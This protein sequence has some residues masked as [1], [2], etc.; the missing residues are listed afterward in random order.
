MSGPVNLGERRRISDWA[1]DTIYE[2]GIDQSGVVRDY[3]YHARLVEL[4]FGN[5]KE[6][7]KLLRQ[8]G[9][10]QVMWI[11]IWL[12]REERDGALV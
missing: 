6:M 4:D 1:L 10:R 5:S 8:M 11:P 9:M 3:N 2:R 7:K 12:T